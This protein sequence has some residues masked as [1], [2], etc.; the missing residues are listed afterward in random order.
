MKPLEENHGKDIVAWLHKA[1]EDMRVAEYL[2]GQE[3]G[4]YAA[5]GFHAQQAAEKYLKALPTFWEID[6][7]KTHV[8]AFL[9]DLVEFRDAKLA[10][11][12]ENA[13]ALTPYAAAARYPGDWP[14]A[15]PEDARE[16]V[17]LAR[18][19]RQA[20]LPLLPTNTGEGS[21]IHD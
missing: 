20:V 4:F 7:P 18:K 8:I 9:L 15:T 1:N 10:A 19:V 11:S 17:E 21:K 12:L 3:Q 16:A 13:A 6:F 2:V 5:V 14:E